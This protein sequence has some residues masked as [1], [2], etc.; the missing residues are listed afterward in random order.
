MLFTIL[1]IINVIK[2]TPDYLKL[3]DDFKNFFK[4]EGENITINKLMSLF[5]YF[6]HL[7]FDD[8]VETL[9]PEYKLTIPDDVKNTI[10]ENLLKQKN[11]N[12]KITT[13]DLAAA[14]RRFISRY[15][16][17]SLQTTDFDEKKILSPYLYK[18]ELWEQKIGSLEEF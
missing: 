7:C 2:G 8:L 16:A 9:Q 3:S 13:K 10:I 12:D 5:F 14:T 4:K 17:G 18:I 11:I 15:L 6:E 1:K